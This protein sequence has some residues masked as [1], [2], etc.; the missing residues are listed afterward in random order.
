MESGSNGW[1]QHSDHR[2]HGMEWVS[3]L[4]NQDLIL[5]LFNFTCRKHCT[6][7]V[8]KE[9]YFLEYKTDQICSK[10]TTTAIDLFAK[11]VGIYKIPNVI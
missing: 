10:W 5:Q 7:K 8:W 4:E 1:H 3:W 2:Q 11:A 6:K 9:N